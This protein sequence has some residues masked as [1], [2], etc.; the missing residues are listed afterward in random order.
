[1]HISFNFYTT[2]IVLNKPNRLNFT[3]CDTKL[4][5][6]FKRPFTVMALCHMNIR[7]LARDLRSSSSGSISKFADGIN[8]R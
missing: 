8:P 5:P 3:S 7:S 2:K 1:M 6:W 4:I